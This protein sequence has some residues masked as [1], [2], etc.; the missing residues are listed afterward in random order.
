MGYQV[1][2]SPLALD[3]L[4]QIVTSVAR[5]DSSAA[6]RLGHRLLDHAETLRHL[7][8]RGGGVRQRPG[9]KKLILRPYLIF[10][11]VEES[12]RR[13]EI[14]RFWHGARNPESLRLR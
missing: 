11:R 14:L 1:I 10:Y 5:E 12:A 6:E 8:Y 2:L 13:V 7:P 4:G 9:V 3:D